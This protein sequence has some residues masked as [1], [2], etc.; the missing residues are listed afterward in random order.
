MLLETGQTLTDGKRLTDGE[1]VEPCALSNTLSLTQT[2]I[3]TPNSALRIMR[4]DS[5]TVIYQNIKPKYTPRR[6]QGMTIEE[7][8]D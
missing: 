2:E 3:P 4:I 5:Q 1:P 7:L 6:I 8:K